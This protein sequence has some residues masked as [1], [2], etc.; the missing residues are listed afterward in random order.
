MEYVATTQSKL[1]PEPRF[2]IVYTSP[3]LITLHVEREG[4]R[5]RDGLV[6]GTE[7][8]VEPGDAVGGRGRGV[9]GAHG[10]G[11]GL[12]YPARVRGRGAH[13]LRQRH[14]HAVADVPGLSRV[15]FFFQ[16][17]FVKHFITF[18]IAS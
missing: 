1:Y 7:N 15:H 17:I 14:P 3:A 5:E 11:R 13:G 10:D 9:R 6:H 2:V 8:A 18:I 12:R 16:F 4:E